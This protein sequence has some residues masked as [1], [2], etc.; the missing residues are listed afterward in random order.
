MHEHRIPR[1]GVIKVAEEAFLLMTDHGAAV[2]VNDER[3]QQL[4]ANLYVALD[5]LCD[6]HRAGDTD[7]VY[8]AMAAL[9]ESADGGPLRLLAAQA[10][11][12]LA[13]A[14]WSLRDR[15]QSAF[16]EDDE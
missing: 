16:D 15:M 8:E 7:A 2:D 12:E 13:D 9:G 14:G 1:D 11:V 4:F 10:I 3:K 5:A 6:Y